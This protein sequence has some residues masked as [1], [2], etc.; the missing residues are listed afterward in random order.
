M[1]EI[2]FFNSRG[3]RITFGLEISWTKQTLS[4]CLA[5]RLQASKARFHSQTPFQPF[6]GCL[7][8]C[9]INSLKLGSD[10]KREFL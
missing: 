4:A 9:K 6:H 3:S 8:D 5:I 7:D 10:P 2:A 1:W